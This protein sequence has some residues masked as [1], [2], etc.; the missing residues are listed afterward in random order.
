VV[1]FRRDLDVRQARLPRGRRLELV[2]RRQGSLEVRI[3]P[4]PGLAAFAS[5]LVEYALVD[6]RLAHFDFGH[7]FQVP[8]QLDG[9]PVGDYQL[10][11][12]VAGWNA[13][14][15]GSVRIDATCRALSFFANR[16]LLQRR[17]RLGDGSTLADGVLT[18][19][20]PSW[21]PE[22][23]Q[24]WSSPLVDGRFECFLGAESSCAATLLHPGRTPSLVQLHSGAGQ[25]LVI[26]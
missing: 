1:A 3:S 26:R 11:V 24:L 14:A 9:L 17:M 16:V 22:V 8:F 20:H 6:R 23:E 18:L 13:Y 7:E 15:E 4:P 10:F 21:P 19:E 5:G 12:H 25:D 2:I